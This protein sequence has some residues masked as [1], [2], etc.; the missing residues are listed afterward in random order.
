MTIH[1][2]KINNN[3]FFY[4]NKTRE[5][6][7]NYNRLNTKLNRVWEYETPVKYYKALR[8]AIKNNINQ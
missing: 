8:R 2:T 3:S 6:N 1:E 5:G 4:I 7:Y